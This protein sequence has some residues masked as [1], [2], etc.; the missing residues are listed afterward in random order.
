MF[1]AQ[2]SRWLLFGAPPTPEAAQ[3]AAALAL[4]G[5]ALAGVGVIGRG[6]PD[7]GMA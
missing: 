6:S 4:L 2:R 3:I 7:A 5:L 1:R